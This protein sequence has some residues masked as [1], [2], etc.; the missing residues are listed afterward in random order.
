MLPLKKSFGTST[1]LFHPSFISTTIKF[2]QKI[3]I[4]RIYITNG[5]LHAPRMLNPGS[6]T[7]KMACF[8]GPKTLPRNNSL[9]N[10][11]DSQYPSS[12]L[13]RNPAH[14]RSPIGATHGSCLSWNKS[15]SIAGLPLQE[16]L[17]SLSHGGD[18]WSCGRAGRQAGRRGGWTAPVA[19]GSPYRAARERLGTAR[20]GSAR[21]GGQR[22]RGGRG[23]RLP[24]LPV[25]ALGVL[26]ASL[27]RTGARLPCHWRSASPRGSVVDG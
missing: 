22:R 24:P 21:R 23:P 2:M 16:L 17:S 3:K 27:A 6:Y 13:R 20:L 14:P 7:R 19:A 26:P 12:P 25:P 4:E 5:S 8:P 10:H 9:K 18:G 11:Q 1:V 15:S